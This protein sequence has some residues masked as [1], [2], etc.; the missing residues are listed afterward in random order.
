MRASENQTILFYEKFSP[1][2]FVPFFD[3][4]NELHEPTSEMPRLRRLRPEKNFR[5][6][7]FQR[8]VE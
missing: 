8:T 1:L 3:T 6:N 2:V 4:L 5:A 7:D